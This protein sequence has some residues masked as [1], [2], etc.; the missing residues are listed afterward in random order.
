MELGYL[1]VVATATLTLLAFEVLWWFGVA[2]VIK[3]L[4]KEGKEGEA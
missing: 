1:E 4:I 3:R 2:I